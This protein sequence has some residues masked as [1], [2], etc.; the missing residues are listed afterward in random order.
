VGGGDNAQA[1]RAARH[2]AS[3]GGG[4]SEA[5]E[6]DADEDDG[7][8][9]PRRLGQVGEEVARVSGADGGRLAAW[10]GAWAGR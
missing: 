6:D 3:S 10:R 7:E 8:E 1:G 5:G 2:A 4:A 9:E